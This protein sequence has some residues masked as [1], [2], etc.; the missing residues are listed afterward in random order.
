MRWRACCWAA[1]IWFCARHD[2]RRRVVHATG[3]RNFQDDWRVRFQSDTQLRPAHRARGR[4]ARSEQPADVGFDENAVRTH[5]RA[6][7]Q[8]GVSLLAGGHSKGALFVRGASAGPTIIKGNPKTIKP[9]RRVGLTYAANLNTVVHGGTA[10]LGTL[11]LRLQ[12]ARPDR[13]LERRR[14]ANRALKGVR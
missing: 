13:V 3:A 14:S 4:S 11:E 8:G 9:A 2:R 5:R 6:G 1:V 10:V 7:A 12:L